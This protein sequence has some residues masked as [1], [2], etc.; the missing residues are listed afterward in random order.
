MRADQF[1]RQH[2]AGWKRLHELVEKAQRSRLSSLSDDELHEL[3]TLY[4]RASSDL[5]RAQT[6]LSG[7]TAGREL[8]HSLNALVLRAHSQV[9]SAPA[10]Q[11][12]RALRF[13][14]YGFPGVRASQLETRRAGGSIVLWPRINRLLVCRR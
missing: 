6:R 2:R 7:T 14:L 13:L 8:I 11:P 9:Y 1:V 3:G 4:R 5:A 12:L 10:P